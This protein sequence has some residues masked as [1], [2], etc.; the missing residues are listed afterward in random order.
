[1]AYCTLPDGISNDRVRQSGGRYSDSTDFDFMMR[2]G[3]WTENFALPGVLNEC[4]LQSY[5]GTLLLFPNTQSLGPARFENLR[6]AGAFL[7]SAA[8]DGREIT[9]ISLLS[10]KGKSVRLAKPWSGALR[11]KKARDASPVSFTT[12][13]DVV[14]FP[15]VAGERYLIEHV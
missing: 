2:M 13:G 11:V 9:H 4:M 10:E 15:T 14:V 5:S 8:F 3:V 12:E 7:V 1:V 6:A